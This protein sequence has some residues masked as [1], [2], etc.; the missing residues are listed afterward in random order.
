[1]TWRESGGS[2]PAFAH[3]VEL[4]RARG[5]KPE[6]AGE[7][8]LAWA[9]GRGETGAV[10]ELDRAITVEGEA[11]ARRIDRALAD[12]VCQALRVRLLVADQGR[13]RIDDYA[14][15]GPLRGWIGVAALR[16]ALNLV[17]RPTPAGEDLL[18]EL[19]AVDADPELQ[20]LKALY[21]AE[22]RE[23]L[24]VSLRALPE[25]S[26][27]VLRLSYVDGVKHVQLG[28]L[29]NV[30]ETTAAR[31][32]ASAAAE[33]AE[34]TRTR[35]MTKLALSPSSLESVTRMVLS[36]LDLSIGRVLRG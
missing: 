2:D 34:A 5:S 25:R 11:A 19:V 15:R 31:W 29:Y 30:H 6:H 8:L 16:V 24:E 9:A 4:C 36:H 21:R 22:F 10:R 12:E 13:I 3:H 1:M 27:T 32:V 7:L 33:V 28:R 17:R 35:L 14:G 18:G 26:R 20:H 23:A